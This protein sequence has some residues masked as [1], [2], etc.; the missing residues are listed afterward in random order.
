MALLLGAAIKNTQGIRLISV[1]NSATGMFSFWSIVV[2]WPIRL[3][4]GMVVNVLMVASLAMSN[5][6]SCASVFETQVGK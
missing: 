3:V 1:L 2:S 4:F 6:E 5:P